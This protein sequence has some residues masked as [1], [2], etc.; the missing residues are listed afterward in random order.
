MTL[1]FFMFTVR[2]SKRNHGRQ[3]WYPGSH[4]T[5]QDQWLDRKLKHLSQI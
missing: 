5:A 4:A 2:I 3:P 1:T